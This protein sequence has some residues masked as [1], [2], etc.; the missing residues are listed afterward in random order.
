MAKMLIDLS[1]IVV[2]GTDVAYSKSFPLPSGNPAFACCVKAASPGAVKVKLELEV[3]NEIPTTEY[4][5]DSNWSLVERAEE[6]L[7][8]IEDTDKHAFAYE[9]PATQFARIK[10]TGI[11][12]NDAATAL[13]KLQ[14]SYIK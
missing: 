9:P 10:A 6:F 3:S 7:D 8:L 12:G 13:E 5:I 2:S 11:T 14:V 1:G 4:A